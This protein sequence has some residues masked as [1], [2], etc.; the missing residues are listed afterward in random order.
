MGELYVIQGR[1][2]CHCE[3]RRAEAISYGNAHGPPTRQMTGIASPRRA[4]QCHDGLL[5]RHELLQPMDG[6]IARLKR[7]IID[8]PL[9]QRHR[10]LNP[11]DREFP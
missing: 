3:A 8:D 11:D 5:P 7:R 1:G 6:I 2:L 9:M 10:C 4:A